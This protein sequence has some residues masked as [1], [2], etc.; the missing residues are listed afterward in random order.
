MSDRSWLRGST[1][2]RQARWPSRRD[3]IAGGIGFGAGAKLRAPAVAQQ[4]SAIRIGL[5]PVFLTNDLDLLENLRSYLCRRW[6]REVRLV[7]RRTYQEITGLLVGGEVDAAWICGYPYVAH[8]DQLTLLAVPVW[9]GQP[10]Y[11]SYIIVD[12]MRAANSFDDLA[13]D[14]HAF[15]D[16]DSNSGFLVTRDL[17]ADRRVRPETFFSHFFYT[18]GHR[19][20][21]RAVASGL[22]QSGSVDG[23]VW[24]V[25]REVE[26][27]LTSRTRVL[28]RSEL[29]GFP[30]IASGRAR[31]GPVTVAELARAFLAMSSDSEGRR[32]LG[33]LRLDGFMASDPSLFDTIAAK[34]E[35]VREVG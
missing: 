20:V 10:L 33:A 12:A 5:T 23:Y 13:G 15:S 3:F 14:V 19:N 28:R 7:T 11:R 2:A 8:R 6:G 17:L 35:H 32:V 9:Q 16:P 31:S 18:Y 27:Q 1:P 29:L 4:S 30:P 22:A 26:P 34:M 21:V 24:E 25:L